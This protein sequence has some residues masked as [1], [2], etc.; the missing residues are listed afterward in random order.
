M[1]HIIRHKRPINRLCYSLCHPAQERAQ[2]LKIR[3]RI[4]IQQDS[5][6]GSFHK[7]LR[8]GLQCA[9]PIKERLAIPCSCEKASGA[10][11]CPIAVMAA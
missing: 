8:L 5:F 9:L 11:F 6:M 7:R 1:N 4:G 2:P 3:R 10:A